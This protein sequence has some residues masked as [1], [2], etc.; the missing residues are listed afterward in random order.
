MTDFINEILNE[1]ILNFLEVWRVS[2]LFSKYEVSNLGRVRHRRKQHI[3]KHTLKNKREDYHQ[4]ALQDNVN[5]RKNDG[6]CR[7]R[8]HSVHVLVATEFC[9]NDDPIHN[10]IVAHDDNNKQ[11]NRASNLRWTT[12]ALNEIHCPPNSTNTSG[13]KG[14]SFD[15][16]RQVWRP[17]IKKNGHTFHLGDF[18]HSVNGWIDSGEQ[19]DIWARKLFGTYAYLNFYY[20]PFEMNQFLMEFEDKNTIN[21]KL[22]RKFRY[23]FCAILP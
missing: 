21:G 9:Q 19:Y 8:K 5:S 12:Y 11:N 1:N 10:T 20:E 22:Y 6:S 13:L 15:K 23:K 7:D 16:D 2:K 14:V 3:I 18:E 17:S 4:V